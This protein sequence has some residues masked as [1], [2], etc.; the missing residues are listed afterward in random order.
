MKKLLFLIHDLGGGGAERVLVDLV[1]RL[2]PT[3][4]DITV[5]ALFG[6]GVHEKRL[7]PHIHYRALLPRAFPANTH[8]MK[9]FSPRLLHRLLV[10]AHYDV[11]I[12]FLEGACARII[13]GCPDPQV[14]RIAWI[15]GQ[16]NN[17]RN[18][19]RSFRSAREALRCYG[20]MER[21]VCV[22][23]DVRRAFLSALPVQTPTVVLRN[24]LDVRR[25]EASAAKPAPMPSAAPGELTLV[26]VGKL[27]RGK[28][29]DRMIRVLARLVRAGVS[30]RLLILGE[31]PQRRRLCALAKR[32]G[33]AERVSLL[34]Y[35][36]DPYALLAQCDL[37]VCASHSE[38]FST[39][40]TEAL[41]VGTPVCTV[42][43]GGM[44][45]LLGENDE[46]GI[47]TENSED[48]LFS[49][50]YRLLTDRALLTHYR[51]VAA[52]W[53]RKFREEMDDAAEAVQALLEEPPCAQTQDASAD[54][55]IS[56]IVPACNAAPWLPRCLDSLLAQ[57]HRVPE[58]IV[59]DDG[60]TDDTAAVALRY[61][62]LDRRVRVIRQEN[63]GANAARLRGVAEAEGAWI[64]FADADD[65][66]A[67]DMYERLLQNARRFDAEISH[68]GY[69]RILPDGREVAYHGTGAL[70]QCDRLRGLRELVCGTRVEPGVWNKLY[71][72][73]LFADVAHR[74]DPNVRINEDLLLNFYLFRAAER[75]IYEDFCPYFYHVRRGSVST[76][77][78]RTQALCESIRVSEQLLRDAPPQVRGVCCARLARQLAEL[79]TL[80]NADACI[81][82]QAQGELRRRMKMLLRADMGLRRKLLSVCAALC[83]RGYA[84]LKR[85]RRA[86]EKTQTDE[87][88]A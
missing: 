57:T 33:V 46:W 24:V 31:G 30:V 8:I 78:S 63:R 80:P 71:R 18:A 3:R 54:E 53:G 37:F 82:K 1:N 52:A 21:I 58:V 42:S 28:G 49:A 62:A 34:G 68:C 17:T 83:P 26:G 73:E 41:L 16:P 44:R 29:F 64:G 85:L 20:T 2:D 43:V 12:A 11:E 39:A 75:S 50:L 88:C 48:A 61:A 47:V 51:R 14:R 15:H 66:V 67:P 25:I 6:G 32:L 69:R 86:R 55:R 74:I 36:S 23:R 77:V 13:G 7:A 19:A 27:I 79:A 35:Q 10:R 87:V 60:S 70:L 56:V 5:L 9:L 22:S 45:E 59:V 81:R 84:A 65:C 72:R 40:A 76:S 38:G 4:S